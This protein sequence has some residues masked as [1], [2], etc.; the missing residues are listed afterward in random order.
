MSSTLEEHN[1]RKGK[2]SKRWEE[3]VDIVLQKWQSS[4]E[5][6]TLLLL[7]FFI[8]VISSAPQFQYLK[9]L[10]LRRNRS[11]NLTTKKMG[12]SKLRKA[13]RKMVVAACGS[14][15]RRCPPPPPPPPVLVSLSHFLL[16]F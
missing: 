2:R 11:Y 12:A 8:I 5:I 7:V 14:F 15:T 9:S 16:L 4:S 13:A 10:S 6:L 3:E 1:E